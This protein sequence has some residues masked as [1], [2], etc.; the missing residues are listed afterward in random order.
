MLIII[1]LEDGLPVVIE[2]TFSK[3]S[4]LSNSNNL[5]NVL[6][7]PCNKNEGEIQLIVNNSFL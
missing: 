1:P 7:V 6:D 4:E 5:P 2:L 3:F